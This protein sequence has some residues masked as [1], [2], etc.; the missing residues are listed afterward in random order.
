M[1]AGAAMSKGLK[2]RLVRAAAVNICQNITGIG[3]LSPD[4]KQMLLEAARAIGG[5]NPDR[6]KDEYKAR[7]EKATQVEPP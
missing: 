3:S 6:L 5:I 4:T 2:A 1:S 7:L